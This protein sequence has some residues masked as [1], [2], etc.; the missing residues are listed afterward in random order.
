TRALGML[1]ARA[2]AWGASSGQVREA[3]HAI[4]ERG[5]ALGW[6]HAA[7]RRSS[8]PGGR[9]M[10]EWRRVGAFALTPVERLAVEMALHEEQERRVLE[11]ELELLAEAWRDAEEIAG[12]ADAL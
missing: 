4:D 2:N 11:G 12:I 6:L 3:V 1:L 8:R 7:A 5:D 9:V 10:A